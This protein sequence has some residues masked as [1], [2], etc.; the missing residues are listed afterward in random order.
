VLPCCFYYLILFSILTIRPSIILFYFKFLPRAIRE[1]EI[2][3]VDLA[4]LQLRGVPLAGA[5]SFAENGA[6]LKFQFF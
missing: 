4:Q 5:H 3:A 2:D 6:S 1:E